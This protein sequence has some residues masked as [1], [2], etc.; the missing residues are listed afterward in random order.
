MENLQSLSLKEPRHPRVKMDGKV[1]PFVD[2]LTSSFRG[3]RKDGM[4]HKGGM[5]VE[6]QE[7]AH[8][9]QNQF[10]LAKGRLRDLIRAR[11]R[12]ARQNNALHSFLMLFVLEGH[13]SSP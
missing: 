8:A 11:A 5:D 10:T 12:K 7:A 9:N 1:H 3:E 4:V 2:R 6:Q 13:L